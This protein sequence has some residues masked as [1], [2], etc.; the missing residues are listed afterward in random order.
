MKRVHGHRG[1][2]SYD[3]LLASSGPSGSAQHH[4][5]RRSSATQ[6]RQRIKVPS[7]GRARAESSGSDQTRSAGHRARVLKGLRAQEA[8]LQESYRNYSQSLQAS[9][10]SLGRDELDFQADALRVLQ[11]KIRRMQSSLGETHR[12][13]SE[14]GSD[15]A[16]PD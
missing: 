16:H 5:R 10:E 11:E 6:G 15:L 14:E 1:E 4:R 8:A 7:N 9:Q 12:L 3:S 13:G 2:Q